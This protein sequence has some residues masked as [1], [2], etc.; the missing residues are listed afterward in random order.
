MLTFFAALR[1]TFGLRSERDSKAGASDVDPQ[2][3]IFPVHGHKPLSPDNVH[4][5]NSGS[6]AD[7]GRQPSKAAPEPPKLID[8]AQKFLEALARYEAIVKKRRIKSTRPGRKVEVQALQLAANSAQLKEDP[9]QNLQ[10]LKKLIENLWDNEQKITKGVLRQTIY[11]ARCDLQR[12]YLQQCYDSKIAK[13]NFEPMWRQVLAYDALRKKRGIFRRT[14]KARDK[15]IKEIWD[16]VTELSGSTDNVLDKIKTLHAELTRPR[17]FRFKSKLG[18]ALTRALPDLQEQSKMMKYNEALQQL[19]SRPGKNTVS[20]AQVRWFAE[21]TQWNF[22]GCLDEL[23]Q[24]PAA[25]A[26]ATDN[27]FVPSFCAW[28]YSDC[29]FESAELTEKV[30]QILLKYVQE[31]SAPPLDIRKW[32]SLKALVERD[33]IKKN[34]LFLRSALDQGASSYLVHCAEQVK[35]GDDN[36]KSQEILDAFLKNGHIYTVVWGGLYQETAQLPTYDLPSPL[37]ETMAYYIATQL[38]RKLGQH[39][40]IES[41]NWLQSLQIV[42]NKNNSVLVA[43]FSNF[44]KTYLLFQINAEPLANNRLPEKIAWPGYSHDVALLLAQMSRQPKE[45]SN[46]GL[47]RSAIL[48]ASA[49][50]F[51]SMQCYVE[52]LAT[53]S[54]TKEECQY[55]ELHIDQIYHPFNLEAKKEKEDISTTAIYRVIE[56]AGLNELNLKLQNWS[57]EYCEKVR[58]QQKEVALKSIISRL[59]QALNGT[60]IQQQYGLCAALFEEPYLL[61][62]LQQ[63]QYDRSDDLTLQDVMKV[64][65]FYLVSLHNNQ[66]LIFVNDC[67]NQLSMVTMRQAFAALLQYQSSLLELSELER[68]FPEIGDYLLSLDQSDH[69]GSPDQKQ[70]LQQPLWRQSMYAIARATN[71]L[72]EENA[73]LGTVFHDSD[74][75][76]DYFQNVYLKLPDSDSRESMRMLFLNKVEGEL[77]GQLHF[78]TAVGKKNDSTAAD[79]LVVSVKPKKTG[80]KSSRG[81]SSRS[82]PAQTKVIVSELSKLERLF[83]FEIFVKKLVAGPADDISF[84]V[85]VVAPQSKP[86]LES[87][88]IAIDEIELS[89][90][91]RELLLTKLFAAIQ[92]RLE[93]LQ[94]LPQS[95]RYKETRLCNNATVS[96]T[97]LMDKLVSALT[98]KNNI[99]FNLM[100]S[101][102]GNSQQML[103]EF[104]SRVQ[105]AQ[106]DRHSAQ[107]YFDALSE[108]IKQHNGETLIPEKP[109]SFQWLLDDQ[110]ALV[111]QAIMMG[112]VDLEQRQRLSP[113]FK[114]IGAAPRFFA[115]YKVDTPRWYFWF[116]C[117]TNA[118][119]INANGD[120][121]KALFIVLRSFYDLLP[122]VGTFAQ[123]IK[124]NVNQLIERVFSE[125][126]KYEDRLAALLKIY[127]IGMHYHGSEQP[128]FQELRQW[129]SPIDLFIKA[130]AADTKPDRVEKDLHR[131]VVVAERYCRGLM[132]QLELQQEM[133]KFQDLYRLV[134]PLT[135]YCQMMRLK[136]KPEV[137]LVTVALTRIIDWG[138]SDLKLTGDIL[139]P[140]LNGQSEETRKFLGAIIQKK[141]IERYQR[142]FDTPKDRDQARSLLKEKFKL[143]DSQLGEVDGNWSRFFAVAEK[144]TGRVKQ[145]LSD[146]KTVSGSNP[147]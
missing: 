1:R 34:C 86:E 147:N 125:E 101:L 58:K 137:S 40:V 97:F 138:L 128:V 6:F 126:H 3:V 60:D 100:N 87:Q 146:N 57:N 38:N 112:R 130:V 76:A 131:V 7:I 25:F 61:D 49:N 52:A 73:R 119:K 120:E 15:Q 110:K 105:Q 118:T 82:K 53:R 142:P 133:N 68:Y 42:F 140:I 16:S 2:Q 79:A 104:V 135:R 70:S 62:Y 90:Q 123:E 18:K 92:S 47:I 114:V 108:H 122:E 129:L 89:E 46:Y 13:I 20:E 81:L 85:E 31:L 4:A 10:T 23:L 84:A 106:A 24:K 69:A 117:V 139:N 54:F 37:P 88:L 77:Q 22:I 50:D 28:Y 55:I 33:A 67:V 12:Q 116:D 26:C 44:A 136:I 71:Y 132:V 143:T 94:Q 113:V 17:W 95:S 91:I 29:N 80:S 14:D 93:R 102:S 51:Q 74:N 66:K 30:K 48:L 11:A 21:A 145:G 124:G 43:A 144:V 59:R 9:Q 99:L 19:I 109:D 36:S 27:G 107:D 32:E 56:K 72:S 41:W 134:Q 63:L 5:H 121:E 65:D 45:F 75:A 141:A 83:R 115:D 103:N 98:D 78:A 96:A 111:K 35:R 39:G 127:H 64:R 8:Q